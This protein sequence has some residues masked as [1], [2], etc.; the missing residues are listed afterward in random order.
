MINNI[1][2]AGLSYSV[3]I[4][5]SLFSIFTLTLGLTELSISE[6][7][8][9][10][11]NLAYF[12]LLSKITNW[13]FDY[14]IKTLIEKQS[15]SM[16]DVVFTKFI[17]VLI[18]I[19]FYLLIIY[20][21]YNNGLYVIISLLLLIVVCDNNAYIQFHKLQT[22]TLIPLGL[23]FGI[24]LLILLFLYLKNKIDI[25]NFFILVSI[26]PLL[27][28]VFITLSIIFKERK[29]SSYKS[30]KI[31]LI[32][33]GDMFT[34]IHVNSLYTNVLPILSGGI[35]EVITVAYNLLLRITNIVKQFSIL[36]T[37]VLYYDD[38]NIFKSR[39]VVIYISAVLINTLNIFCYF[40][41]YEKIIDVFIYFYIFVILTNILTF[42]G[43]LSN[44]YSVGIFFKNGLHKVYRNFSV[45]FILVIVFLYHFFSI[46][47]I[48]F[49]VHVFIEIILILYCIIY[50]KIY[51]LQ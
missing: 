4:L 25:N 34:C 13:G 44:N 47:S 2:L 3:K 8:F 7:S 12:S 43:I 26:T 18:I 31:C 27:G 15:I 20:F 28:W 35:S 24:G 36:F 51:K 33:G 11:V 38:K 48:V 32:E 50:S 37:Q 29:L 42:T 1:K 14:K 39:N 16:I 5:G 40:M 41:F 19:P 17:I 46:G 22:K 49:V 23:G 21:F 30:A 10:I 9:V 6:Y 45:P